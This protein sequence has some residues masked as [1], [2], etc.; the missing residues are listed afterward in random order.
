MAAAIA[1]FESY[2]LAEL[3]WFVIAD[4]DQRLY[5]YAWEQFPRVRDALEYR[6]QVLTTIYHIRRL[7]E[8]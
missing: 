2:V 1:A 4:G 5:E 8:V 3:V 6:V 7:P